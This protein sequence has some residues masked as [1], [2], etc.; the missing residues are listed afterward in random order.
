M[1]SHSETSFKIPCRKRFPWLALQFHRLSGELRPVSLSLPSQGDS[2][3]IFPSQRFQYSRI[4]PVR[5]PIFQRTTNNTSIRW[6]VSET[7]RAV[8]ARLTYAR[9]PSSKAMCRIMK[10][11]VRLIISLISWDKSIKTILLCLVK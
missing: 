2:R 11:V 1:V 4:S 5:A 3:D 6:D 7:S 9:R 8:P 10:Q